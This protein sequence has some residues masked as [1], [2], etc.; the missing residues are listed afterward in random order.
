MKKRKQVILR[1]AQRN[2]LLWHHCEN[3][4]LEPLFLIKCN[5]LLLKKTLDFKKG[6]AFVMYDLWFL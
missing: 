6:K 5:A 1:I 4:L 2:V 3:T